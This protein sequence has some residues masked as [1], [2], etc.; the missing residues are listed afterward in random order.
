MKMVKYVEHVDDFKRKGLVQKH[1]VAAVTIA[2]A[3]NRGGTKGV[4]YGSDHLVKIGLGTLSQSGNTS[5]VQVIHAILSVH[6]G[7]HHSFS[8]QKCQHN[9]LVDT[10]KKAP[11][12]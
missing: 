1:R 5:I 11:R 7:L 9:I 4:G 2:I 8:T 12:C 3:T 10:V 6:V